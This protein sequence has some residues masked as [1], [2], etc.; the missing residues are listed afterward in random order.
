[1]DLSDSHRLRIR[2]P[3]ELLAAARWHR[4]HH[5]CHLVY[6]GK[7][8]NPYTSSC[9]RRRFNFLFSSF[10]SV[11]V[12]T[13]RFT[14]PFGFMRDQV[15][16]ISGRRTSDRACSTDCSRKKREQ[17]YSYTNTDEAATEKFLV[18][19]RG[20]NELVKIARIYWCIVPYPFCPRCVDSDS[21][22]TSVG[23]KRDHPINMCLWDYV[24]YNLITKC[25]FNG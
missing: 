10:L 9:W 15:R 8:I 5:I 1:M 22:V 14:P 6:S 20:W 7:A 16:D 11:G 25:R 3:P 18:L 23:R 19:P 13:F 12:S 24:I 17:H 4:D 21:K 2:Q